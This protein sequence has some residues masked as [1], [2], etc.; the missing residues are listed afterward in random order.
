MTRYNLEAAVNA[1]PPLSS[2]VPLSEPTFYIL[3][4][5]FTGEKH[6]Y[7]I[8]KDV[9]AL[10]D[11][12]LTLSTSTLYTALN[13]LLDQRLIERHPEAP[14]GES[15]RQRK[16]YRLTALGRRV[17]EAETQR[18]QVMLSAAHLHLDKGHL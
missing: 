9:K 10:S 11:A 1:F 2:I 18:M 12:K 7:A 5:L 8:L 6:G 3:L 14:E 4:S 16:V 17:L 13:R 15:A